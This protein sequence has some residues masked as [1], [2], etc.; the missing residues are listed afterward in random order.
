MRASTGHPRPAGLGPPCDHGD[1]SEQAGRYQR[2]VAGMIGAL[3]VL[4]AV[5]AG[6]AGLQALNRPGHPDPV[7]P[8][9]YVTPAKYAAKQARFDLLAPAS[10][11][12]GW[13]ATTVRFTDGRP[14]ALA[15]RLPDRGRP[16]RRP[17]A[18]AAAGRAAWWPSTS[19]RRARRGASVSVDGD[20]WQSYTDS[21][22]DLALVRRTG[23]ATTL[24][25][26]HEV[27]RATL[28]RYVRSLR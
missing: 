26:G 25:V 5:I 15:P 17:R 22:G 6:V 11:P 16:L 2:S 12:K 27:P 9:D 1:V 8:V 21:G 10:L 13:E 7:Q 4:V 23:G 19:T 18:G 28:A 20:R 24:V 14:R 3:I